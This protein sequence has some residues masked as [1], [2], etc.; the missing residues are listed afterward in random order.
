[1]ENIIVPSWP[2]IHREDAGVHFTNHEIN[3]TLTHQ[4]EVAVWIA[5]AIKEEGFGLDRID[6]IFCSDEYLL[7]INREH[8]EHDDYTDIITFP[9]EEDP[10][11][12][13]IYISI[14]R[15]KEN[16]E[17]FNTTF[18][19]ELHR[20]MIHGVLHLCGYDDHD[21][22]DVEEIRKKENYY[23]GLFDSKI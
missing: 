4:Q 22:D 9:L 5:D 17:S 10:I 12:G 13:E 19:N 6:Y 14:D 16:A 18:E 23:L 15:V 11:V 1:M 7:S 3:F 2:G 21:D 8:L 20:V